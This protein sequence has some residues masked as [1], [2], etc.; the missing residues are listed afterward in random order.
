[1][2]AVV[3]LGAVGIW[4]VFF[5]DD[6]PEAVSID[7][8]NQQLDE[9]LGAAVEDE[10]AE[11]E[12]DAPDPDDGVTDETPAEAP[13]TDGVNGTWVIDSEIGTFD[14][15]S[16]SGSFAGFRVDEELTIGEVEAVGR[17]DAVSG[18]IT[19]DGETLTA[20][21][22]TV[23]LTDLVSNDSR[24]ENAIQDALDTAQF[25]QATFVLDEPVDLPAIEAGG[26]PIDVDAT[27]TLTVHGV[28]NPATFS[29]TALVRDDGFAV[30]T[31]SS[32]VV[33]DDYGV[34]PPSAPVVVSVDDEGTI[35]LQL[36]L[37]QG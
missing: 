21:D 7:A 9:D 11:S 29:L 25:P 12:S 22:V 17:T 13:A 18:S 34:T 6:A 30:I 28:S 23:R 32:P 8:A 33:F 1:M 37:T 5:S 36:I 35:E 16:A 26:D 10:A 2:A 24:R 4:W 27:G 15:E 3:V 19:I 20:A 31:G 14:F